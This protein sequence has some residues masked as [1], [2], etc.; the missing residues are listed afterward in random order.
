MRPS[1]II[2]FDGVC[3]LCESSVRFIIKRDRAGLFKFA[4]AQSEAGRQL[5][6]DLGVD[7]MASETLI[8]V[9]HGEVY[10]RSDAALTIAG[11]LRGPWRLLALFKNIPRCLRD[12]VYNGIAKRRYRWFGRKDTCM[13][14]EDSFKQ[15]FL[16]KIDVLEKEP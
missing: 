1:H 15:R 16:E 10:Y 2:V 7:A 4:Q 9:Q 3:V 12:P 6:A 8:L 11:A 14:P 13:I 5:Q